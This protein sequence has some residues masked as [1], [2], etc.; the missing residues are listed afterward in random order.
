MVDEFFDGAL[1]GCGAIIGLGIA[2][3]IAGILTPVLVNPYVAVVACG[4]VILGAL[5][6]L[7]GHYSAD[8]AVRTAEPPID[9]V[10]LTRLPDERVHVMSAVGLILLMVLW[11]LVALRQFAAATIGSVLIMVVWGVRILVHQARGPSP[12]D[13]YGD[14]DHVQTV[15]ITMG[16]GFVFLIAF[17]IVVSE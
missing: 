15:F 3:A 5:A 7:A 9:P 12:Y 14:T 6:R 4:L 2:L 1:D 16:A 11:I 13:D 10:T 8:P 17:L